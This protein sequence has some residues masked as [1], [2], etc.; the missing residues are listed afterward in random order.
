M[1]LTQRRCGNLGSKTKKE[2]EA[3]RKKPKEGEAC[4]NRHSRG[5]R[6]KVACGNIL[7]D[8]FHRCLENPVGFSTVTTSPATI[9]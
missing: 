4:G 2:K 7:I 8:D 9:N 5:N 1:T 3:K 6:I